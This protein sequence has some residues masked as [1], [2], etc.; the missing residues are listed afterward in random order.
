MVAGR[1]VSLAE[2]ADDLAEITGRIVWSTV[3]TTDRLGRP[4]ARIMHPVWEIGAASVIGFVG[5]RRT[6]V[7]VAHI[8]RSPW[9]TCAYWSPDHDAAF[10]DCHVTWVGAEAWDRL[11]AGYDP[12][13]LWPDGP[14]S[15]E[16]AAWELRPYRIQ[17]IRGAD[18]TAGLPSP[19]WTASSTTDTVKTVRDENTMTAE[20]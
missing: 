19:I 7:K 17:V 20:K 16:F 4:R 8:A 10:L 14:S 5:T 6:P 2:L 1:P 18:V 9:V 12:A 15:P 3:S 11:A 13:T